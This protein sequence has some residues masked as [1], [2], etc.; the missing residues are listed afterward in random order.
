MD[1][2]FCKI[3]HRELPSE[4]LLETDKVIVI[5]DI[6]PINDGHAL[7]IPKTHCENF[8]AVGAEFYSEIL[9]AIHRASQA[10]CKVTQC[11]DFNILQNNGACAGQDVF[12]VHFHIIPRHEN[13]G[14]KFGFKP[15]K[16]KKD[17]MATLGEDIR[18]QLNRDSHAY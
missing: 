4:T 2:V 17:R 16:Y 15:K 1:C 8:W 5:L 11:T 3:I 6:N 12:H 10:I 14:V 9:Q 18:L 7:V 13:D